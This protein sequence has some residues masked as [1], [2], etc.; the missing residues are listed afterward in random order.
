[1]KLCNLLQTRWRAA[2][3]SGAGRRGECGGAL[4]AGSRGAAQGAAPGTGRV[5]LAALLCLH[6]RV[7]AFFSPLDVYF[8]HCTLR[9]YKED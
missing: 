2:E 7:F 1:M 6:F 5:L 8:K 4:G 3:N 9:A